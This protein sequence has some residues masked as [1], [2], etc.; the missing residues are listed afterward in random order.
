MAPPTKFTPEMDEI[1]LTEVIDGMSLR[2]I[3]KLVGISMRTLSY[4]TRESNE[5]HKKKMFRKDFAEDFAEAMIFS[6]DVM[7]GDRLDIA[8]NRERDF[9]EIKNVKTGKMYMQPNNAVVNRDRLICDTMMSS[10]QHRNPKKYMNLDA[11]SVGSISFTQINYGKV[12]IKDDGGFKPKDR[13][14]NT[15][16][17]HTE[18][19]P[20][21]DSLGDGQRV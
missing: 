5:E 19:L 3:C 21:T 6:G 11:K 12:D 20:A 18:R 10:L 2:K 1:I 13:S 17:I 15:A 7:A 4:W 9:Y 16:Q 14:I 8:Q